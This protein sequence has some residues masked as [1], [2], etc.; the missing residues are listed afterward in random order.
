MDALSK[1]L[2][3][4]LIRAGKNPKSVGDKMLTYTRDILRLLYSSDEK[5]ILE[6]YGLFGESVHTINELAAEYHTTP[7]V[8]QQGIEACLRKLAVSPEWV[9][10]KPMTKLKAIKLK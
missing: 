8:M 3:D 7:D 9:S 10:I 2:Q 5:I 1:E 6:Y 4:F